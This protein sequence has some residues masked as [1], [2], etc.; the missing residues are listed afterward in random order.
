MSQNYTEETPQPQPSSEDKET[1]R[2]LIPAYSIGATDEAE[3]ALVEAFLND[4]DFAAE[5]ADY[6]Q[7]QDALLHSAPPARPPTHLHA[8]LMASLQEGTAQ[9]QS[10]PR[11][12]KSVSRLWIGLAAAI[13]LLVL[14]NILWLTQLSTVTRERSEL[15]LQVEELTTLVKAITQQ[16]SPR[17][18][19]AART[20]FLPT[21]TEAEVTWAQV[22]DQ[23][24]W[25]ALFYAENLPSLEAGQVY[26]LWLAKDNVPY[27]FGFVQVDKE[28]QATLIF[29]TTEPVS[30]YDFIG[31][32]A[33]PE[34]G[35][36]APSSEPLIFGTFES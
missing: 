24:L 35:S 7:L 29:T 30:S 5:L 21:E 4:A 25:I 22:G 28:G 18:E 32:T 31:I 36:P 16:N 34:G 33:E 8:R 23:Q 15:A 14:S 11:S 3:I 19:L 12:P 13:V 27:S 17:V 26:Q 20:E 2:E 10:E 6:Q 1:A 9:T